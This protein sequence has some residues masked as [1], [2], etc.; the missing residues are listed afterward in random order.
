MNY[1][2]LNITLNDQIKTQTCKTTATKKVIPELWTDSCHVSTGIDKPTP[3][4]L[5]SLQTCLLR[6]TSHTHHILSHVHG[7]PHIDC[8]HL[9]LIKLHDS[10]YLRILSL[11]HLCKVY[12]QCS[13]P[14]YT[15]PLYT[16]HCLSCVCTLFWFPDFF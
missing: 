9:D 2:V 1:Y 8:T 11:H 12:T 4:T 15:K 6:I 14:V 3:R 13:I 7:H 5:H 16:I 10:Q